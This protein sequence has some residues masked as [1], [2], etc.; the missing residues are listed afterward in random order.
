MDA[1]LPNWMMLERFVFRRDD[2][3]SFPGDEAGSF[4]VSSSTSQ[5]DPFRVAFLITKP[6]AISRLYVQW[7]GGLDPEI[8]ISCDLVTAH[9]DLVLFRLISNPVTLEG[10]PLPHYPQ[11]FFICKA[12]SSP[13]PLLLRRIP[14][15]VEPVVV[16][17]KKGVELTMPRSFYTHTLGLLGRG[18]DDFAMAQLDI[19]THGK[20]KPTG[21]LC[22]LRS[23]FSNDYQD[24]KW[25]VKQKLEIHY[26]EKELVDLLYWKA[27]QVI[28]FKHYLCWANYYR[29]GVLFCNVF[30][31]I[32]KLTYLRLPV[33]KH[34]QNSSQ[35]PFFEL[36]RSVCV[37]E[38]GLK[39][40]DISRQDGELLGPMEPGTGFTITCYTL[41]TSE[42]VMKWDF[43]FS[44][45]SKDLW[46]CNSPA[47]LPRC[48]LMSPLVS[49]DRPNVVHF[50]CVEYVDEYGNEFGKVSSVSIDMSTKAVDSTLPYID[51]DTDLSG[52]DVDMV[53]YR[54]DLLQ[55]F[56]PSEFPKFLNLLTRYFHLIYS[57]LH[58]AYTAC[59]LFIIL[60]LCSELLLHS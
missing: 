14:M 23:R 9:R 52:K 32:P 24:C 11:D 18:E 54:A 47:L 46:D 50:L 3:A 40:I 29:G 2:P 56:L 49:M 27:D 12:S 59:K 58:C 4:T 25:E 35:H 34:P 19:F 53:E 60:G 43:D 57:L 33:D 28:P 42:S 6:P 5:G 22:V 30:E 31:E 26:D 38:A 37:T 16:R 55:S 48:V 1:A 39:L 21:E 20:S 10:S 36:R 44:I 13:S 7:P 41:N 51:G 17:V 15:C 8:G 45:T